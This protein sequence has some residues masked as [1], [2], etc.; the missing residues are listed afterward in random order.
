L[1]RKRGGLGWL[2]GTQGHEQCRQ[3]RTHTTSYSTLIEYVSVLY[4]FRDIAGYLSKVADFNPPHLH[5]T[6]GFTAV[7]FSGDLWRQ[8]TRVPW[9][10][11][12]VVCMIPYFAVLV[13]H[14]LVTDTDR[15][16]DT[17][18]RL[19][20]RKHSIARQKHVKN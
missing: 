19:V 5:L 13:K 18:P 16:T 4:R 14:L 10:S 12:G 15:Q 6:Q 8:K 2:G 9:L 17:G 11:S 3:Y 20:P 1:S 7:E